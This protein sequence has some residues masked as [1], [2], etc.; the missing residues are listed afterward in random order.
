[1]TTFTIHTGIYIKISIETL[2]KLKIKMKFQLTV[3]QSMR[4]LFF[5][6]LRSKLCEVG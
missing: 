3:L 1:M 5:Q 4:I 6:R 2:S